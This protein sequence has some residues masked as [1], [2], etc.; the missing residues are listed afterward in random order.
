[1]GK[2]YR[3]APVNSPMRTCSVSKRRKR[4][5][6]PPTYARHSSRPAVYVITYARQV[7]IGREADALLRLVGR[8]ES[9]A[10]DVGLRLL[11]RRAVL[12]DH[13]RRV[14]PDRPQRL[15]G[16]HDLL[17]QLAV[18][19]DPVAGE[20]VVGSRVPV[21]AEHDLRRRARRFPR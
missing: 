8:D 5:G 21:V 10:L 17:G 4:A 11:G 6:S 3:D 19:V 18:D 16:L 1:M 2:I 14:E 15:D 13:Q 12:M 20:H 7:G 9:P